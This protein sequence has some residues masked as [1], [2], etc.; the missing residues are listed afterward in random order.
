MK[1]KTSASQIALI[2]FVAVVLTLVANR[3]LFVRDRWRTYSPPDRTFSMD[4]PGTPRTMTKEVPIEG[5]AGTIAANMVILDSASSAVYMCT[6][7][8]HE[9]IGKK[10]PDRA[11]ESARDGSLKQVHGTV[12]EQKRITV[13]G[14]PAL[15][16]RANVSGNMM[17]DSRIV[18]AGNRL[19][20]LMVITP[21]GEPVPEKAQRMFGSFHL[22]KA[23][24]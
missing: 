7:S 2:A 1:G 24:Q 11:L 15:E 16:L 22:N 14:Y 8:E 21:E 4:F 20:M 9:N 19:Y 13:E 10:S 5:G 3:G 6:Y 23:K 17:L 18:V 12:I